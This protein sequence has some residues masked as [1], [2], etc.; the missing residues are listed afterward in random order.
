[1]SPIAFHQPAQQ[2]HA[3]RLTIARGRAAASAAACRATLESDLYFGAS[4]ALG[5]I[6]FLATL[7]I[8]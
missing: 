4:V 5:A 1:M 3:M 7:G 8:I 6:V 2:R